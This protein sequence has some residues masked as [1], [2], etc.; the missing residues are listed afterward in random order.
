MPLPDNGR[1]FDNQA[2]RDWFVQLKIKNYNSS[3]THPQ[4][5]GEAEVIDKTIFKMIKAR[6]DHAKG[7]WAHPIGLQDN[8]ENPNGGDPLCHSLWQRSF[9][10]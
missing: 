10:A 9:D 8:N 2:F 4:A 1:Q 6:L 5:H 3:P 7:I